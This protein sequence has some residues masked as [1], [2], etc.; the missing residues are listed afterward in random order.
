[1]YYN[2]CDVVQLTTLPINGQHLPL[3]KGTTARLLLITSPMPY[4]P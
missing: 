4:H 1:M 3:I 2:C